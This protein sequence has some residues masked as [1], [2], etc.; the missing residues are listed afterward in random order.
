MLV[1]RPLNLR[2]VPSDRVLSSIGSV[3]ETNCEE[4]NEARH[5]WRVG[6]ALLKWDYFRQGF[7]DTR[8]IHSN[9]SRRYL[10][11]ADQCIRSYLGFSC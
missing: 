2:Q 10:G 9:A 7:S 5:T 6:R 3:E 8:D 11:P 4:W 1:P